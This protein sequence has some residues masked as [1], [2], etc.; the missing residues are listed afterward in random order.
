MGGKHSLSA[1]WRIID[2]YLTMACP[3]KNGR[4]VFPLASRPE[5]FCELCFKWHLR[6]HDWVQYAEQRLLQGRGGLG[7]YRCC[8]GQDIFNEC[9]NMELFSIMTLTYEVCVCGCMCVFVCVC[10]YEKGSLGVSGC[11]SGIMHALLWPLRS[12]YHI[13]CSSKRGADQLTALLIW[14]TAWEE[15]CHAP[16]TKHAPPPEAEL[17][18]QLD[19]IRIE[20]RSTV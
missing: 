15:Q 19:Y 7:T 16:T 17:D 8:L 18:T 6:M 4:N 11:L 13:S 9:Q 5:A 20:H 10:S 2:A 14:I 3:P 1:Q 12:N